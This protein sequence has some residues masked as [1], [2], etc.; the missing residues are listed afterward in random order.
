MTLYFAAFA[1]LT[2]HYSV[3]ILE[4]IISRKMNSLDYKQNQAPETQVDL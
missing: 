2:C 1:L 4:A 3:D